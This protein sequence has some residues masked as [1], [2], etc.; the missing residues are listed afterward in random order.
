MKNLEKDNSGRGHL[1]KDNSEQEPPKTNYS[2]QQQSDKGQF[3]K[4]KI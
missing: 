3:C 1:K 4:G 2:E